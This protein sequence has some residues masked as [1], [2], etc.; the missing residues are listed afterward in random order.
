MSKKEL[1]DEAQT[2][3]LMMWALLVV[4][5]LALGL[6]FAGLRAW[7]PRR[8]VPFSMMMFTGAVL[9]ALWYGLRGHQRAVADGE[10]ASQ[11]A[12]IMVIAAQLARQETPTLEK[13]A[14]KGGPA[15]AAAKMILDGRRRSSRL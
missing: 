12:M 4:A 15:A 13:I 6:A 10:R 8:S 3:R 14:S 9:G 7:F 1:S 2:L 5:I 11:S